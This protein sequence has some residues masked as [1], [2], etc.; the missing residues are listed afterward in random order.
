MNKGLEA[1][2]SIK[3]SFRFNVDKFVYNANKNYFKT[4]EKDLEI[5]DI[6]KRYP[7]GD[8]LGLCFNIY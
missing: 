1:L 7:L 5:L 6:I 2:E 4:V 8:I 3:R